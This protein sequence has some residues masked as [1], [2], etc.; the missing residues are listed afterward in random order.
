MFQLKKIK[1]VIHL[2]EMITYTYI[3]MKDKYI[4]TNALKYVSC[5]IKK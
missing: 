3:H 4:Y 1:I 2:D 5:N